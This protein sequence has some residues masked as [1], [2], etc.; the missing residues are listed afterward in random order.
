MK[1]EIINPTTLR[2]TREGTRLLPGCAT[3]EWIAYFYR[4]CGLTTRCET[5]N[6]VDDARYVGAAA[7]SGLEG[8]QQR[9]SLGH[10][11]VVSRFIQ[12]IS[13][14]TS[15]MEHFVSNKYQNKARNQSNK[16][17]NKNDSNEKPQEVFHGRLKWVWQLDRQLFKTMDSLQ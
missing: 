13:A 9:P 16:E 15:K 8:L 14:A 11:Q 2:L 1:D 17:S 5:T 4:N 12:Q 6:S 7:R 10:Q 3:K